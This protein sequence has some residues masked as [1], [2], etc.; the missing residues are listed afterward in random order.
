M[1]KHLDN[2]KSPDDLKALPLGQ[3]IDLA[4]EIRAEL[5]NTVSATG[6]HLASS[7]GVVELTI[8]LHRVFNSPEDKIIWD[9]GHQSYPHK[10]L[11]GR[12]DAFA[13][14]RQYKG[15][16]GFASREESPHDPFSTGHASTSVSAALGMAIAR[17]MAK[18]DYHVIAVIGDGALT[19]G[20]AFEALNHTG[21][22]GT[23]LIVVLND[24]GMSISPSTGALS[25]MLTRIRFARKVQQAKQDAKKVVSRLPV[26][27]SIRLLGRRLKTGVK[28]LIVPAFWE[29]LGLEYFGPLDGHDIAQL[30]TALSLVR[31]NYNKPILVHV[32]TQKGRGYL[33]AEQDAIGYHGVAPEN[34]GPNK[35][36]SYSKVFS[37][38][39]LRL[40]KENPKVVAISAAMLEGTGLSAAKKEFPGRV[41]DVG[42][43][44]QHAVTLAAGL[45]CQGYI[46]VVALYSTF[47]QRAYDQL[48]HDVCIQKLPVVFAIDRAGIVGDDGKTHQGSFDIS[49]LC[50]IPEIVVAAPR[51]ENE[52]QQLL[53][54]AVQANRPMAVRYPRGSGQGVSLENDYRQLP[55]GKGEMLR[56]GQD[57][58]IA[59]LGNTVYAAMEAASNLALQGIQCKVIDARFAKP[60][61]KELL[62]AAASQTKRLVTV[63]ENALAGGFGSAV[64][65]LLSEAKLFEVRTLCLG[66]PDEFVEQGPQPLLRTNYDLDAPGIERRIKE[67]FP[68]LLERPIKID[69]KR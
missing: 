18:Q 25:R 13:T 24:N 63:E 68:E 34:N 37:Q 54:T 55:I 7:L 48:I 51:D 42:I 27:D 32:I 50:A 38:T 43:C 45:A 23:K 11:T 65:R 19:G 40:F 59:A 12:K 60:L 35:S 15:L 49:Y 9:V 52:L 6:G 20:M 21:H 28:G 5:V 8:A 14:I 2:I 58:A 36:P 69:Y 3:L 4:D 53:F 47:L 57:L 39:M 33:P 1:A 10:L 46:P 17:D 26:S 29:E 62:L 64:L 56:D 31:D 44:E 66:L 41:F 22:L 61:D 30:E 67:A 16:C